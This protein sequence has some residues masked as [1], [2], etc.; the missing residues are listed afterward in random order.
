M[1]GAGIVRN[2]LPARDPE[3][4]RRALPLAG[5]GARERPG[6]AVFTT[7]PPSTAAGRVFFFQAVEALTCSSS[8][9]VSD[10][11]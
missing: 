3:R 11:L 8:N 2:P 6:V 9:L 5:H 7:T 10:T 4:A 1:L